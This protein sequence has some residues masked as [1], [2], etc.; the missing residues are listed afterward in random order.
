MRHLG[1]ALLIACSSG[2]RG[3]AL[4]RDEPPRQTPQV[5]PRPTFSLREVSVRHEGKPLGA[6]TELRSRDR[7]DMIVDVAGSAYVYVIRVA[8]G[9][10]TSVLYPTSTV[11]A[12]SGTARVPADPR[13]IF[14]LDDQVG[15]ERLYVIAMSEPMSE[16][17]AAVA[18]VVDELEG[19]GPSETPASPPA[20]LPAA[21]NA[22]VAQPATIDAGAR[23]RQRPK[24]KAR[25]R[26]AMGPLEDVDRDVVIVSTGSAATCTNVVPNR[27]GVAACRFTI[28]HLP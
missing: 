10:R 18:A 26:I 8:P 21:A 2:T 23:P 12:L 19:D 27:R 22:G 6:N 20:T 4:E 14:Q 7:F 9:K 5:A 1:L 13:Q 3:A 28:R 16:G 24:K 11:A 17:A 15:E 25:T